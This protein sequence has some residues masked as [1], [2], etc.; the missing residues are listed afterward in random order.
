MHAQRCNL[1]ARTVL[2]I[3]VFAL[4]VP[5]G[6]ARATGLPEPPPAPL[7]GAVEQGAAIPRQEAVAVPSEPVAA[8]SE[9]AAAPSEPAA[10]PSQP[11]GAPSEPVSGPSEP[12]SGPSEPVA[13]PSQPVADPST[14]AV[15]ALAPG[16]TPAPRAEVAPNPP[17]PPR[18]Y[19]DGRLGPRTHVRM[20]LRHVNEGIRNVN[21]ELA[22]GRAPSQRSLHNLGQNVEELVPAVDALE[23]HKVSGTGVPGGRARFERGLRRAVAGAVVLV[24]ALVRSGADT[25][26]SERLLGLLRRLAGTARGARATERPGAAY[27]AP[28]A[29]A[30]Q[31]AYTHAATASHHSQTSSPSDARPSVTIAPRQLAADL[32]PD[33]L[34]P[35]RIARLA[36]AA[37]RKSSSGWLAA[38]ALLLTVAASGSFASIAMSRWGGARSTRRTRGLTRRS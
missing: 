33:P 5:A 23:R 30:Q 36:T 12:V 11:V 21:R 32:P 8:P 6:A 19:P 15:P 35:A 9:P 20:L 31:V 37:P 34:S 1:T 16:A 38:A 27:A 18:E 13:V 24:A 29:A 26:E 10:R 14:D 4:A 22:A 7:G 3:I 28:G 25:T 17:N 2:A